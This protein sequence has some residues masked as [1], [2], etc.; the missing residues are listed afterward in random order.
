[1][2]LGFGELSDSMWM[3][4][5]LYKG[6]KMDY[7]FFAARMGV[8]S[9]GSSNWI[10]DTLDLPADDGRD[11]WYISPASGTASIE[12]EWVVGRLAGHG[13]QF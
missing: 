13:N 4:R 11:F 12:E 9:G 1:V 7:N 3:A 10:G 6:R 5:S 8:V 2:S